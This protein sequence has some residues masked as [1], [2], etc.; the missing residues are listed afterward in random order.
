M[1]RATAAGQEAHQRVGVAGRRVVARRQRM[2]QPEARQVDGRAGGPGAR[3][4]RPGR[5]SSSPSRTGRAR[6]PPAH[7]PGR[8]SRARAASPRRTSPRAPAR[9][10]GADRAPAASRRRPVAARSAGGR[11]ASGAARRV[12]RTATWRWTSTEDHSPTAHSASPGAPGAQ[13]IRRSTPNGRS[14]VVP[15]GRR[16]GAHADGAAAGGLHGRAGA[17]LRRSLERR[18]G[19]RRPGLVDGRTRRRTGPPPRPR[20]SLRAP[21]PAPRAEPAPLG[22]PATAGGYTLVLPNPAFTPGRAGEL[23]FTVTGPD[24]RPVRAFDVRSEAAMHVVVVRRDAA[25]FQRLLPTLGPD[26]LWRVPLV[27]PAAGIYRLYADFQPTGGAA[28]VLG[29]DL[30]A[31]GEFAPVPFVPDRVWQIDG[32]QVRLDGDLLA[33]RPSQVFV[34]I[35]RDGAAV[36]DLQPYL[37]A[38]GQLVALRR[39]DLGFVRLQPDAAATRAD[40]PVRAGDRVHRAAPH[41]G[42]LPAV[43]GVPPRPRGARRRVHRRHQ[44]RGM[45]TDAPTRPTRN[46]GGYEPVPSTAGVGA[47]RTSRRHAVGAAG[48]AVPALAVDRAHAG[49]A[50][51]RLGRLA[52]PPGRAPA[53]P[54]RPGDHRHPGLAGHAGRVRL[55][56]VRTARRHRGRDRP[57]PAVPRHPDRGCRHRRD[58]ARGGRRGHRARAGRAVPRGRMSASGRCRAARTGAARRRA[59]RARDSAGRDDR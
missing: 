13:P 54:P 52:V 41:P 32:Y 25:G 36:T 37:G 51:R 4:A 2:G 42:Q 58:P 30:F 1:H 19:R 48:V 40:R 33:G 24:G 47:A 8:A 56:A 39:S 9:A 10:A 23:V 45:I 3:A 21:A 12:G 7:R 55:V 31:P 6:R 34:T 11:P 28:Q 35:S 59:G 14:R 5:S 38:F 15:V 26:G 27:L 22:L 44:G 46:L 20:P 50:G 49:R 18:R 17:R 53:R 16:G 43:P 57:A 29:T